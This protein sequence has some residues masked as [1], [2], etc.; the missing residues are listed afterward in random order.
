MVLPFH[1]LHLPL[2]ALPIFCSTRLAEDPLFICLSSF[3]L[4]LQVNFFVA[5]AIFSKL[6]MLFPPSFALFVLAKFATLAKVAFFV[7][8]L[9][10]ICR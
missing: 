5:L 2:F 6:A 4:Y 8:N 1:C 9:F 3:L 7:C 10:A